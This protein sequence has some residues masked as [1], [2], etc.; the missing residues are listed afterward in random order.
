MHKDNI[1]DIKS[2]MRLIG[3]PFNN[4]E[5]VDLNQNYLLLLYNIA[6]K[7]K[8]GLLFLETLIK[9]QKIGELST[10]LEKQREKFLRQ[11][12]TAKRA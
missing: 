10:E 3:S 7:N 5:N 11:R 8:I 6:K 2:I 9:I 12:I 4:P 1:R